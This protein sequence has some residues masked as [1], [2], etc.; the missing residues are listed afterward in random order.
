MLGL[1]RLLFL[2]YRKEVLVIL[3]INWPDWKSRANGTG[4][5]GGGNGWKIITDVVRKNA[6]IKCNK[7]NLNTKHVEFLTWP[8]GDSG[9]SNFP[10]EAS[11]ILRP[12]RGSNV[13]VSPL[14][15]DGYKLIPWTALSDDQITN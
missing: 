4:T 2:V 14:A 8:Y 13:K 12:L 5:L 6:L 3:E 10:G 15:I 11:N 7:V 9:R 1:L